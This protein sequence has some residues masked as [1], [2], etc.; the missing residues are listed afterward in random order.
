MIV[1]A[2]FG[3]D[4][5]ASLKTHFLEL[6]TFDVEGRG[7]K[8]ELDIIESDR[9]FGALPEDTRSAW[10]G[11]RDTIRSA[12]AVLA[13][14][15]GPE[16]RR[17]YTWLLGADLA[18]EALAGGLTTTSGRIFGRA[19]GYKLDAHLDSSK[20]AVTC[21]LYFSNAATA[22]EGALSLYRP[23]RT[24]AVLHASTYYPEREEGIPVELVTTI[25]I[26]ENLFVAFLNGPT[27]LH[28]L[29]RAPDTS[30]QWRFAYQ[31]HIVLRNF[32]IALV[33]DRLGESERARWSKHLKQ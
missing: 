2:A 16:I 15:F 33:A 19:P 17:K 22:D 32:D 23:E 24:P 18:D 1:Q 28:G 20:F 29:R 12:S 10:R 26:R 7:R 13:D 8:L 30:L 31:C 5:F 14:R 3:N 4:E 11:L 25:P 21:L 6:G 27:S 9:T